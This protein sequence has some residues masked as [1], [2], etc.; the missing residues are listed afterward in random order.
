MAAKRI[1]P[2][3]ESDDQPKEKRMKSM[4]SFASVIGEVMM[5]K[6][7]QSFVNS[8]EP[9]LRRVVNEEVERGIQRTMRT[10][11]RVPSFRIQ[12]PEPACMQLMFVNKDLPTIFTC[13]KI[14]D[15]NGDSLNLMLV[16]KIG[17]QIIRKVPQHPIKVEIVVIDG[18]FPSTDRDIWTVDEFNGKIVKER[19][20]RRPLIAKD[21][22][23]TIKHGYCVTLGEIEFT[24]NSSW[25]RS[26]KFKL[27]ARVV[28]GTSSDG[29]ILEALTEAFIVK[30]QRGEVYK[31]HYPPMLE[32]EVWRLEK[33]GKDGKF[34]KRLELAGIKSVQDFLKLSAIDS[35]KLKKIL[36][37]KRGKAGIP[38][39]MWDSIL[40][41]AKTCNVGNKL[42][43]CQGSNFTITLDATCNIFSIHNI[44]GELYSN[45]DFRSYIKNE[46]I[47]QLVKNAYKNWASLQ[48]V[49]RP[50]NESLQLSQGD[51]VAESSTHI[52]YVMP[53]DIVG[54]GQIMGIEGGDMIQNNLPMELIGNWVT[55]PQLLL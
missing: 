55:S 22:H 13:N 37:G 51:Y 39:R 5:A 50:V 8:F 34:H 30:D 4:P 28:P 43:I 52:Q 36:G 11:T 47:D 32:D 44:D 21:V 48:E 38:D 46:T 20:G 15:I 14:T 23:Y 41:H 33:I 42:Y 6:S 9:L 27:G 1:A 18:D 7:L 31:K 17:D 40:K 53:Y 16:E 25:I 26:R 12:A 3:I 19:S 35:I 29:R 24:D 49:D 54:G 10:M 45:S 2:D